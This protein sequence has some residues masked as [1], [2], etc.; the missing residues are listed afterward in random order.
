MSD[1]RGSDP[2]PL[3]DGLAIPAEDWH[4]TPT[5]VRSQFLSL[6]K[7]VVVYPNSADN[8]IS[9]NAAKRPRILPPLL[10]KWQEAM[11]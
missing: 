4:Q 10:S 11:P 3:P 6:L 5:S 2:I 8:S 1:L 9:A 7:R